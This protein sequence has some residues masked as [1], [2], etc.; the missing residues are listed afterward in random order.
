ML[1]RAAR[2]CTYRKRAAR[3]RTYRKRTY[4]GREV[5]RH[6]TESPGTRQ[7]R[8]YAT[9]LREPDLIGSPVPRSIR[10]HT[11]LAI[12][13]DEFFPKERVRG[14]LMRKIRQ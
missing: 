1:T 12:E 10:R 4:R 7:E 13:L 9:E 14:V 11:Q 6:V 3:K 5:R 2:K 8:F